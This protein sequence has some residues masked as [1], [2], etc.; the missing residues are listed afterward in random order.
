[1]KVLQEWEC[2]VRDLSEDTAWLGLVDVTAGEKYEN[3]MAEVPKQ[4]FSPEVWEAMQEG[5]ILTWKIEED[6]DGKTTST[7]A[8][9]DLGVWT[10][11]E[12][13]ECR[14]RA[15]ELHKRLNWK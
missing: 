5:T 4:S 11:E 8:L 10:Q 13:D 9:V 12:I 15:E 6:D 2:L 14:V 1:M 7:F 3:E